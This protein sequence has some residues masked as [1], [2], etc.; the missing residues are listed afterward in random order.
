MLNI[1]QHKFYEA[2]ISFTTT[3]HTLYLGFTPHK[4]ADT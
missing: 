2:H 1:N 4:D 3:E